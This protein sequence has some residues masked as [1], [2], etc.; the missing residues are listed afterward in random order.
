MKFQQLI[1]WYVN[2]T[3]NEIEMAAM[4]DHVK[5]CDAC[6]A[7]VQITVKQM[8][9]LNRSSNSHA[10]RGG[11]ISKN[12]AILQRTIRD[13]SDSCDSNGALHR[14]M[15]R[16]LPALAAAVVIAVTSSV[17]VSVSAPVEY[18]VLSTAQQVQTPVVQVAFDAS[19]GEAELRQLILNSG[20][21]LIGNPT[22]QGIYRLEIPLS[23]D[24]RKTLAALRASRD[25]RW[26][27]LER[28]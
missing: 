4:A 26:A 16:L 17:V 15:S 13:D 8:Q 28:P 19:L 20:G 10:V 6:Q 3:L 5:V 27:T 1:P 2:G 7:D 12:F 18:Q 21:T 23:H 25:V 24:A 11:E 9:I 22:R 14:P